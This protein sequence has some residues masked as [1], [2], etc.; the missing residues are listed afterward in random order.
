M[1][2]V[3]AIFLLLANF[4]LSYAQIDDFDLGMPDFKVSGKSG[5]YGVTDAGK[6]IIPNQYDTIIIPNPVSLGFEGWTGFLVKDNGYWNWVDTKNK[7][8]LKAKYS[9]MIG[10]TYSMLEIDEML[11]EYYLMVK[12]DAGKWGIIN[13]DEDVLVPFEYEELM[14]VGGEVIDFIGY[15]VNGKWGMRLNHLLSSWVVEPK[16]DLI[17]PKNL[18]KGVSRFDLETDRNLLLPIKNSGKWGAW[19]TMYNKQV[20]PCEYDSIIVVED[21]VY[22]NGFYGKY[23]LY[24]VI[25]VQNKLQGL[26]EWDKENTSYKVVIAPAYKKIMPGNGHRSS[27]INIPCKKDGTWGVHHVKDGTWSAVEGTCKKMENFNALRSKNAVQLAAA[28]DDWFWG[29]VDTDGKWVIKAQYLDKP[30]LFHT[31][32]PY[33]LVMIADTNKKK[34][35]LIDGLGKIVFQPET[36]SMRFDQEGA[37]ELLII[38]A[39]KQWKYGLFDLN[40]FKELYPMEFERIEISKTKVSFYKESSFKIDF[41]IDIKDIKN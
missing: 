32:L 29:Y 39:P 1:Y 37:A 38:M 11:S 36:P 10:F 15:K 19:S 23:N 41:E 30:G 7:P 28:Y 20:I 9:A 27:G 16:W 18:Y 40:S 22:E 25:G 17:D 35:A 33:S 5:A 2:K 6:Q 26:L 14:T 8:A 13:L 21:M 24:Q 34:W 12:N 31:V 4:Q 3:L